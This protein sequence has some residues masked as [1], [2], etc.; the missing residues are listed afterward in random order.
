MYLFMATLC[1][2]V[3][4]HNNQL[5]YYNL[6][7]L[8]TD[9]VILQY[10]FPDNI[11]KVTKFHFSLHNKVYCKIRRRRHIDTV[12][13]SDFYAQFTPQPQSKFYCIPI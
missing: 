4:D 8:V 3:K 11:V 5:F 13:L 12:S 9:S 1:N 6:V 7:T 10:L 2:T